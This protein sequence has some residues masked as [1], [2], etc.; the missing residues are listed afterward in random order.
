MTEASSQQAAS[1]AQRAEMG[2]SSVTVSVVEPGL[3]IDGRLIDWV[4]IDDV[5]EGD[6]RVR[7]DL[8]D[9]SSIELLRL[10]TTHDQFLRELR[11]ARRRARFAALTIATGEPTHSYVARPPGGTDRKSTRL[12]SSH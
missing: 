7:L 1:R 2:G 6:H 8:A 4:D 10:G 11:A 3:Q 9:G 5:H 12:N